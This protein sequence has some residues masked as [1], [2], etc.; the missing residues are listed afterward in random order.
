MKDGKR[1]MKAMKNILPRAALFLAALFCVVPL[2][3]ETAAGSRQELSVIVSSLPEAMLGF[4]WHCTAPFLR[5]DHFLTKDNN[6]RAALGLELSPVSLYGLADLVWTPAAFFELSAGTKLGSGWNIE[7]FGEPVYGIGINRPKKPA[8]A[9]FPASPAAAEMDGAPFD[10]LH[11]NLHGGGAL[12]FD[13]AALFPGDW[14]HVVF[15][16]YHE[17]NYRGYSR[18]AVGDSWV[19]A[20]DDGE[21]RNGF[22]WYGNFLLGYRMPIFLNTVGILTEMDKYLYGIS[23]E[24]DWGGDLIRW[25]FSGIFGFTVTKRISAVLMAQCRTR[26]NY[27]DGDRKNGRDYFYQSRTLDKGNPL[28]LEF[29]RVAAVMNFSIK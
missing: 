10:G 1:V 13:L 26:R 17:L 28:R 6:V 7:L 12:Q 9:G 8:G 3:A 14:H 25:T 15:R 22:N 2:R 5:G 18:A 20:N 21:N 29:Y 27:R 4:T 11:W 24:A 19:F 23:N 16:G